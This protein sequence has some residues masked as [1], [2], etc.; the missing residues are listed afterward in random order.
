MDTASWSPSLEYGV[1]QKALPGEAVS[2]DLHLVLPHGRGVL[3]AVVDGIGHGR[4]AT[5]AAEIAV[6]TLRARPED[7]VL[8]H[9]RRCHAA[10]GDSRG[11]V[12]TLADHNV[13]EG[14]LT[15]SGVGNV[16]AMLYR[17][18]GQRAGPPR[19][20]AVLRGGTVGSNLPEPF[21]SVVLVQ[22]H[23]VL[24]MASDGIR[25]NFG[26]DLPL[27]SPAQRLAETILQKHFKGNDDGLVL[28]ARF[29]E[30]SS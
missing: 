30:G 5:A 22:P 14:T 4:E 21:A 15:L 26:P 20:C 10:L 9:F 16:E 3:L 6:A 17:P 12:M 7:N 2:G 25:T 27:R 11:V 23:D 29:P 24:I 8:Q 19:E 18:D 13:R 1:A 28:V